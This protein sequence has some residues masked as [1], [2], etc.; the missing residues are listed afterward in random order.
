MFLSDGYL[1]LLD[2]RR[3]DVESVPTLVRTM[4]YICKYFHTAHHLNKSKTT[5]IKGHDSKHKQH[6]LSV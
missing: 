2:I 6:R 5:G 3:K 4:V 1:L